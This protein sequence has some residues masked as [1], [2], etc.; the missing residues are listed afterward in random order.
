MSLL[1]FRDSSMLEWNILSKKGK[2]GTKAIKM[3]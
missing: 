2:N 1:A 3:V